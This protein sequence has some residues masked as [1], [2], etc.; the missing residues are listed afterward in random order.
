MFRLLLI[1]FLP[2]YFVFGQNQESVAGFE[3]K[4]KIGFLMPHRPVM[5]HLLQ[6]HSFAF[7][8]SYTMQTTGQKEWH[9]TFRFPRWG[10]TF[11]IADFGNPDQL[12]WSLGS[13]IFGELP[14]FRKNRFA[15]MSK[16]G[17]G[18]GY[19]NKKYD[20]QDNP[21]NN[22]IGSHLN[23]LIV[24]GMNMNYQFQ[25]SEI[26]LGIDMTHLSNGA[27]KLPNL[28]IN[29]PYLSLG[30]TR[31]LEELQFDHSEKP[32]SSHIAE[33]NQWQLNLMGL[34]STKQIYPTGGKNYFVGALGIFGS[35]KFGRK[36]GVDVGI[37]II[38]NASL[39]DRLQDQE[40]NHIDAIQLG[41]FAGY[42]I[43]INRLRILLGMG[44]YAKNTINVDGPFYHRLSTR[45]KLNKRWNIHFGI[46]SHWGKA[47]YFE[48][49][50]FYRIL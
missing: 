38:Y 41:L 3:A 18:I 34:V 6:G 2:F 13:Y 28:G 8:G 35:R 25:K 42:F 17:G 45:Y 36:S 37:D 40:Y 7:E 15:L 10:A 43:P 31:Y 14:V 32:L 4:G 23:S 1:V 11:F 48:F 5:H 21:K 39:K 9:Q 46:K 29:V 20:L 49:G 26:A 24:L 44:Y 16:L 27:V 30:Y 50:F 22:S 19:V 33:L 47:D 12:G